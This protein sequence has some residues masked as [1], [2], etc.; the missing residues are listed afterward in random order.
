VL[1]NS[2][3]SELPEKSRA[4]IRF[5]RPIRLLFA[6]FILCAVF[7]AVSVAAAANLSADMTFGDSA[8][9]LTYSV[10]GPFTDGYGSSVSL[11]FSYGNPMYAGEPLSDVSLSFGPGDFGGSFSGTITVSG[12]SLYIYCNYDVLLAG[13]PCAEADFF[14]QGTAPKWDGTSNVK[15]LSVTVPFTMT[16]HVWE[17]PDPFNGAYDGSGIAAFQFTQLGGPYMYLYAAHFTS[18]PEPS[19]WVLAILSLASIRATAFSVKPR[20]SRPTSVQV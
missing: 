8:A 4:R 14:A 20:T 2:L 17:A 18:T 11:I 3:V 6:S 16:L 10:L 19:S 9:I 1:K 15:N 5:G 12:Q 7:L 13:L